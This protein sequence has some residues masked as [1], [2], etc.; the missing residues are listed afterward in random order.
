MEPFE[1][2][3]NNIIAPSNQLTVQQFIVLMWF[4]TKMLQNY[5]QPPTEKQNNHLSM[6][7]LTE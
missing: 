3:N 2:C 7:A 5:P 4:L 1:T 6:V